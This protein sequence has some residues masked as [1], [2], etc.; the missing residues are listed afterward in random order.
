[1]WQVYFLHFNS[2]L[3][4]YSYKYVS[5]KKNILTK[6][7]CAYNSTILFFSFFVMQIFINLSKISSVPFTVSYIC[8]CLTIMKNLYKKFAVE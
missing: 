3:P 8:S 7:V 5:L 4:S 2:I 6:V 1:M